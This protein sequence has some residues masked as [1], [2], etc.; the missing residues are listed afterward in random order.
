MTKDDLA[1][2]ITRV[3][4]KEERGVESLKANQCIHSYFSD[5]SMDELLRISS[6]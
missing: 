2:L 1:I 6:Q 4:F 3:M 5:L